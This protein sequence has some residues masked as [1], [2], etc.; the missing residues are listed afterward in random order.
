MIICHVDVVPILK[1]IRFY[2]EL[3]L[4]FLRY[5]LYLNF[6]LLFKLLYHFHFD[7]HIIHIHI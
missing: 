5:Y 2:F 1:Y 3:V 6:N 7:F 4:A